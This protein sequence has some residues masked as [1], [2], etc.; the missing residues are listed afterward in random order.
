MRIL[1]A[2]DDKMLG[3]ALKEALSINGNVVDWFEDGA[4]CE[5]ALRTAEFDVFVLDIG[6]P[7]K[8]GIEVLQTIRKENNKT[9]VLILTAYDK[10]SQ[11]VEGLNSG[12]DDYMVKPFDILE[13]N[14]R[15]NSLV[16]RSKGGANPI[17]SCKD[18]R[19]DLAKHEIFVGDKKIELSAKE[20]AILR[21][22]ME[23]SDK[24]VSKKS[25]ETLLYSWEDS[26]ESNTVEV[27]IHHLRKKIGLDRIKTIRGVGYI[28]EKE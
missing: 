11:K 8:S 27:H 10:I 4:S 2:E 17:L 3:K 7:D 15:I 12:A 9:P 26:V 21:N 18:L 1:L 6:L 19:M 5:D 25:L 24:V 16:R 23:N 22:L 13:L 14:A 20:F 28:I